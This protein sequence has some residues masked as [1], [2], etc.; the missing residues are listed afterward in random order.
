[1]AL[2]IEKGT[3]NSSRRNAQSHC[4]ATKLRHSKV[5]QTASGAHSTASS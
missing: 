3:K 1:M 4:G 2:E 5:I